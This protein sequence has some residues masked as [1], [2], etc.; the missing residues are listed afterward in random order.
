MRKPFQLGIACILIAQISFAQLKETKKIPGFNPIFERF[1]LPGGTMGNSVQGILQDSVG[2]MWFASQGGLH[3]FD[4]KNIITY[5]SDPNNPNSLNSDYIEDIYLDSKGIIWLTHWLGGGITSYD[6]DLGIFKRYIHDP[7]D[8]ESILDGVTGSIVEDKQGYI[9][10]GGDR[11]LSR[12][13]RETGLFKRFVSDPNDPNTLSDNYIRGL[14]IDKD[15]ILWVATGMPW[16]ENNYGGLN[17]FHSDTESFERF[18]NDPDDPTS[19]SNN[20]VRAMFEDSR[21]NFWV[22]TA[23]DGLHQFNKNEGTFARFEYDKDNPAKLSRPYLLGRDPSNTPYYSHVTSIFEDQNQRIWITAVEGGLE[24]YDPGTGT[25]SHFEM[26]AGQNQLKTNFIWQTYQSDDGTIWLA[27]GGEGLAVY[28]VKERILEFPFFELDQLKDSTSVKRGIIKDPNGKIWIGQSQPTPGFQVKKSTIWQLDPD[29]TGNN[30]GNTSYSITSKVLNSFLGSLS[31]DSVGNVWVGTTDGY[32]TGSDINELKRIKP[33]F[34]TTSNFGIPPVRQSSS[35]IIWIPNWGH[36]VIR[37]DINTE[38]YEVIEHNPDDPKSLGGSIVWSIIEDSK[39]DI[40][41]GGGD[42]ANHP[43]RPL[44]LDR[45]DSSTGTFEHFINN[46]KQLGMVSGIVEDSSGTLWFIDWYSTLYRLDPITGELRKFTAN[47]RLV[48]GDRLQ[49][50]IKYPDGNIWLSTEE[51]LIEIDPESGAMSVYN[52][53]HGVQIAKGSTNAGHLTADGELL[54]VRGNGFHAFYPDELLKQANLNL[55][56][57]RITGFRLLDENL[58]SRSTDHSKAVLKEPIWK[59]SEIK[60]NHDQNTFS[61]SV[62]CFDFYDPEANLLQFML[63]GYDRGWRKDLLEGETPSYIHIA[64]G[65]YTFR[66][67]GANSLGVWDVDG[68][69]LKIIVTPPWWQTW[70]AYALYG[71]LF[72]GAVFGFYRIQRNRV[73]MKERRRVQQR[74]LEQAREIEKAY[75]QLKDT[76]QQLIHSEKMASLGELTA[77]I[78]HEIQNPLNFVNNFAEVNTELIDELKEAVKSGDIKEVEDLAENINENEKKIVHHGKRAE[79]IVKSMLQHSR[80]TEGKLEPTD[81]NALADEYLR[82]AF[83][84]MRAKDKSFNSEMET[85]FDPDIGKVLV[86]PQDIG[87]VL[88]NLITNAFH[89]LNQRK[90]EQQNGY[91]PRIKVVTRKSNGKVEIRVQDN[92]TGIPESIRKKVFEPFFSTK[93]TGKGT[94]LGLSLSYDIITKG[95]GGT[96]DVVSEEGNGTEFIIVIPNNK[97]S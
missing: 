41:I 48:D 33:D 3:R 72:V 54:F 75:N 19:I 77:G 90:Q 93:G 66:L 61:F 34:I 65:E 70:W 68:V 18:L 7:D 63:E 4:G 60:L 8:I 82:L 85:D 50:I 89:A 45:F 56:D 57:L 32:Y 47:N 71:L 23:G 40:W 73:L 81:I 22:G 46:S 30:L 24:V 5:N 38:E 59:T 76:Q 1:E 49:T 25:K 26:G 97:Q 79:E 94:G 92:G 27:T 95:H 2:F 35:G 69:S 31:L 39:G 67:R 17:R 91:Q 14:Y 12:L 16:N 55:P 28:K 88:L 6:P 96:I 64:P 87:R 53:N 86:V 58:I 80:G 29:Q 84:G 42:P 11:G 62:A 37:Y 43:D 74:E 52:A 13:D 10:I 51:C 83:H 78:A 21:G 15:G 44:F 36:G 20:K 9:W